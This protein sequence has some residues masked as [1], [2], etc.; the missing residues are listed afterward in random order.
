MKRTSVKVVHHCGRPILELVV[1]IIM[2]AASVPLCLFS[3]YLC[4]S[5]P[6]LST[7]AIF[8]WSRLPVGIS[9]TRTGGPSAPRWSD[10]CSSALLCSN[11]YSSVCSR[12]HLKFRHRHSQP[13]GYLQVQLTSATGVIWHLVE[14]SMR[15][16]WRATIA[17][18]CENS[19]NKNGAT[20]RA[21]R[22][23]NCAE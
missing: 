5:L 13:Q 23:R 8:A 19:K 16:K 11:R 9:S 10:T 7:P 3:R 6:M 14:T 22:A 4:R 12:C 17:K 15:L 2:L 1:C 18:T 21:K 20:H